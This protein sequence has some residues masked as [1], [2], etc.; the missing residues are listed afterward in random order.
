MVDYA[1]F[2]KHSAQKVSNDKKF[3]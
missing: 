3:E 1:M 2:I